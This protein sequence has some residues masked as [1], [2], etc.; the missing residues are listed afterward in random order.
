MKKDLICIFICLWL[1]VFPALGQQEQ[2]AVRYGNNPKAGHVIRIRG[3]NMYYETYGSGRPLLLIH[4]NEGSIAS[5]DNQIP[6]FSKHYLVI[7][8]DSRAQGKS[9]D[10]GDSLSY[11]MMADDLDALLNYLHLDSC[12]VIG[13][14]DGGIDGLLLAIR[15]PDKVKKLAETGANLWPDSTALTPSEYQGIV[16]EVRRASSLPQTPD[17][18]N[19]LKLQ[20]MMLL[21][22]HISIQ[23]L[24]LIHCPVLVIG[25]DH[26]AIRPAHTLLIYENIPKAYLWILPRSG[27]NTLVKYRDLFNSTVED[28]FIKPYVE[29]PDKS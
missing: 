11:E 14:S 23:E 28:F 9:K 5:M 19:H 26:D 6:F 29:M 12:E 2:G 27:H 18:K 8:A 22:P 4:G 25:G 3:F 24:Q 15:H 16:D 7:A 1:F 21:E 10:P 13:W 17:N 20:R